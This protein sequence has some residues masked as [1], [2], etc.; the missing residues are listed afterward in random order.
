MSE[1]KKIPTHDDVLELLSE[2]AMGGSIT[3]TAALERALRAAPRS[4]EDFDDELSRL[5]RDGE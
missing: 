4:A 1:K 5:L 3:P 2:Q